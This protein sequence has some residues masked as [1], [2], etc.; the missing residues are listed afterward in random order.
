MNDNLIIF[1]IETTGL[2]PINDRVISI[3]IKDLQHNQ[4]YYY[5]FNPGVEISAQVTAVNGFTNEYVQKLNKI[6]HYIHEIYQLMNNKT[7]IGY[8]SNKFD[9]PFIQQ[10]FKRYNLTLNIEAQ[11]DVFNLWLNVEKSRKL[12][13]AYFRFTGQKLE[14]AHNASADVNATHVVLQHILKI[15]KMTKND[16][17]MLS[18]MS[19]NDRFHFGKYKGMTYQQVYDT[20]KK[21]LLWVYNTSSF[22]QTIKDNIKKIIEINNKK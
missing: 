13:D 14:N 1:D 5:E 2:S 16:A 10:E 9:I 17:I 6:E 12:V 4:D 8:N 22:D 20:D 21:Y 3:A 7:L 19:N 15:Y 18:D 11:I